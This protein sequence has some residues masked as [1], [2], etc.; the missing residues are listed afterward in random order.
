[1]FGTIGFWELFLIFV[2]ALIVLGPKR[3]PEAARTIGKFYREI[4]GV[5]NDVKSS[6]NEPMKEVKNIPEITEKE[7]LADTT[8]TNEEKKEKAKQNIDIENY[9]PKREKISFKRNLEEQNDRED[10]QS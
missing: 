2:V 1:M 10:K 4:M 3:L 9:Q 5:I 7:L 6:V 8:N